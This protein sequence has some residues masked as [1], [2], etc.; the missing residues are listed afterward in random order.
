MEV[1]FVGRLS[2]AKNVDVVIQAVAR[3]NQP[4][5]VM[6]LRIV[7]DGPMRPQ[8][9]K[10]ALSV[11]SGDQVI[12]EGAVPQSRVLDFYEGAHVLVLASE[13]EGWPKAIAE[14]MAFGLVCIGSNRGL[15]PQML[16]E[17]RGLVVEPRDVD[18]LANALRLLVHETNTATT[19]SRKG[20]AWAQHFTLERLR[21]ALRKQLETTWG[22]SLPAK[23]LES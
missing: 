23:G 11:A 22:V 7:G 2:A 16:G 5:K 20:A 13:T 1:L 6:R 19:L 4:E 3:L 15:V 21:E 17:Q 10:L 14:A 9:Q 12:F 18:G 8:L